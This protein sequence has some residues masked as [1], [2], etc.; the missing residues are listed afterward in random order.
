MTQVHN[1][2]HQYDHK[3]TI[4]IT[5]IITNLMT[6]SSSRR[7]PG[8]TEGRLLGLRWPRRLRRFSPRSQSLSG[9]THH[10]HP[11][12]SLSLSPPLSFIILIIITI[13]C[14]SAL[15]L[16]FK[17]ILTPI[18]TYIQDD[19]IPYS[20][21]FPKKSNLAIPGAIAIIITI[22]HQHPYSPVQVLV[23]VMAVILFLLL[24]TSL[25]FTLSARWHT[26]NAQHR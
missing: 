5:I 9:D 3:N 21:L 8:Q 15:S 10:N 2:H 16:S 20:L 17:P 19:L 14:S 7:H 18:R 23:I 13:L 11:P 6:Q 4:I 24:I 26:K 22:D 25:S 1:H 12:S